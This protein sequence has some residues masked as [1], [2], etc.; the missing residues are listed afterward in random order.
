MNV[1]R[2]YKN[3]IRKI[4]IHKKKRTFYFKKSRKIQINLYKHI[5]VIRLYSVYV[6][7]MF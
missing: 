4:I 3:T 5:P 1:I 6:Y 2:M 7:F